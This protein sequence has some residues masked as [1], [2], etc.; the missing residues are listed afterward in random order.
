MWE[1]DKYKTIMKGL[2]HDSFALRTII[3]SEREYFQRKLER[4]EPE[5]IIPLKITWS[6][7]V[8]HNGSAMEGTDTV[9]ED[10]Q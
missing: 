8:N 7:A 6:S 5:G 4:S 1:P 10:Q 3:P 9:E 2:G